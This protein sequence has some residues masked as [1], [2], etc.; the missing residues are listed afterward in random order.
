MLLDR[1]ADGEFLHFYTEVLGG[2]V[3]FE[4]VQRIGDYS[5]LRRGEFAGADGRAPPAAHAPRL[6]DRRNL[7]GRTELEQLLNEAWCQ[8]SA[9]SARIR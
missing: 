1:N 2:R 8:H 3:F 5:G 9:G 7:V 6:R 4:V